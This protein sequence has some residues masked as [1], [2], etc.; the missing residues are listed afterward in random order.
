M[1]TKAQRREDVSVVFN[2]TFN[3]FILNKLS[4]ITTLS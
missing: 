2:K 1:A 3:R 4:N